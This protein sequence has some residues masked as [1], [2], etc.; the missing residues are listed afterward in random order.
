M[1][2]DDVEGVEGIDL[3]E[4]YEGAIPVINEMIAKGGR[5]LRAWLNALAAQEAEDSNQNGG[6]RLVDQSS[7]VPKPAVEL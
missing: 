4:Y 3:A 6:S 2:K 7:F 1:L 5:G